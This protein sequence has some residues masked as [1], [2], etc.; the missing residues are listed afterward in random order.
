MKKRIITLLLLIQFSVIGFGQ[1]LDDSTSLHLIQPSILNAN[2]LIKSDTPD[3]QR[4]ISASRS[5][6]YLSDLPLTIYV[7][8][9]EEIILNGY[10]TLA[11]ALKKLPGIQV[12][13]PGTGEFSEGFQ[14]RGLSGNQYTKIL[15]NNL[16]IKPSVVAGMPI[17][18]Q[19]PIRQAERIEVIYGPAAAAYGADAVTGVINIVLKKADKGTFVRGD[20]FIGEG[21]FNYTN[22]TIGGKAGKNKNILEYSFYGNKKEQRS[23]NSHTGHEQAYNPLAELQHMGRKINLNGDLYD[24]MDITTELLTTYGLSLKDFTSQYYGISYNGSLT[25]PDFEDMSASG[26]MI[27]CNLNFRG[28]GLTFSN[29][30]RKNH[31]SMGLSPLLYKYDN[32]QN[33]WAENIQQFTLSYTHDFRKVSI[34]TN[35][36]FLNYSMD[37]TSSLGLTRLTYDRAYIYSSSEDFLFEQLA[38]FIPTSNSEIIIGATYQGSNNLPL[39]NIMD[40]PFNRNLYNMSEGTYNQNS[41]LGNFGINPVTYHNI[42]SFAQGFLV[43]KRFHFLSGLRYDYN[44]LYGSSINPRI[45]ILYKLSANYSLITSGGFAYKAPPSSLTYRSL[46]YEPYNEPGKIKYLAIPAPSLDPEKYKSLEI[47]LQRNT[48]HRV[49]LNLS[50]F[51]NV[52]SNPIVNQFVPVDIGQYP[53]ATPASDS[54]WATSYVNAKGVVSR[55][56]GVQANILFKDI[57][58]KYHI[59]GELNLTLSRQSDQAPE[60]I[61]FIK[62]NLQL[63]PSHIGQFSI[64]AKPNRH[65]YLRA[66]MVWMSQWIRMLI[67]FEEIYSKLFKDVDGFFSLD[68]N[69]NILL[70]H[71]LI[72]TLKANNILDEKYGGFGASAIESQMIYNP[73]MG[74]NFSIGLSYMFN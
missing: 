53:D 44:S 13:Q 11:D 47:G 21:N 25:V 33:Y 48:T 39:T 51:Y 6:K 12:S 43:Y 40:K 30:N 56:Y 19:I 8:S 45:A 3:E 66:N 71:N 60:L 57:F 5:E 72:I 27:G 65:L 63:M 24:P 28:V 22:F 32:P 42:S 49:I 9:H 59:N 16:P 38:T 26:H 10:I 1:V 29:M 4:V 67:P 15:V 64:S 35:M 70:D 62:S 46:A 36:L 23:L 14:L 68:L 50:G 31:S 52:I 17:S 37:N 55:L 58:S 7:I 20:I 61:E 34:T 41:I 2:N 74:R 69:A 73:Q 18:S 54:L